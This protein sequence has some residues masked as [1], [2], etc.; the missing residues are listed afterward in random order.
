MNNSNM[1]AD[2]IDRRKSENFSLFRLICLG[3]S[4][5][6]TALSVPAQASITRTDIVL[7]SDGTPG[8][9]L[10]SGAG[11]DTG[12]TNQ[13]A[14]TNDTFEYL[15]TVRTNGGDNDLTIVATL[16]AGDVAPRTG[17]AV[18]KWSFVP[19][20][21]TGPGSSIS[22]N[23]QILTCNLGN[24]AST[25][26]Q[27]VY[28]N[29]TVLGTT[30]N[31][32]TM[33]SP[34]LLTSSSAGAG[35]VPTTTAPTLNITAAPYYD[36]V[37][38]MSYNGNPQAYGYRPASGPANEDGF[39]HRP[40]I[41]LVA[42]NPN[43]NGG[44]GVEQL[45]P[46][47][48]IDVNLD[49]SGYPSSVVLDNWH[50]GAGAA[51]TPAA[52]GSFVDGCGNTGA[53]APSSESGSS[54]NTYTFVTDTGAVNASTNTVYNGGD[55][56]VL[57]SSATNVSVRFSGT[58]TSF[59]RRP[60]IVVGTGSPVPASEWWMAQ[61][62]V[63]LWTP[64]ASYTPSVPVTHTVRLGGITATSIT[65]QP[66][67]GNVTTN[68]AA[69]Y[70]MQRLNSGSASQIW[71]ADG[72]RPVPFATQCDPGITGDCHTNYM[73][74]GQTVR[75]RTVYSNNGS[76]TQTNVYMCQVIDRTAMD[77][78]ANFNVLAVSQGSTVRYGSRAGGPYFP[79]TDSANDPYSGSS[80][81]S[82]A[83]S[84]ASCDDPTITW[85]STAA[86][87]QAAGGLVYVRA[88]MPTVDGGTT[89]YLYVDGLTLR[90]TS[91]ATIAVN[92]P[93]AAVR[94]AGSPITEGTLLRI[95]GKVGG[96][97]TSMDTAMLADQ[98]QVVQ[99]RNTT[100]IGKSVIAPTSNPTTP[101][102]SGSVV[103]YQ[104]RPRFSTYF[105]PATRTV[106]VTDILPPGATYVL[107]SATVGAVAQE[108]AISV[109]S[110][111]AG[112]TT[113]TWTL[114]SQ[115]PYMGADGAAANLQA[116]VFNAKL[117]STAA[118]GT[119]V[120][121]SAAASSGPDDYQADCT[122]ST[123]TKSFGACLKAASINLTIQ[124]PPGFR[125]EK[126]VLDPVAE[127]GE[128]F[129]YRLGYASLGQDIVGTDIPDLIDVLPFNGD[130]SANPALNFDART[131][132]TSMTNGA[133]LLQSVSPPSNDATM[134]ILYTKR[135]PSQIN[136][137]PQDASNALPGGSTEWCTS[138][139]FGTG[140][141]P[142][143]IGEAT[144]V[145]LQPS[146]A[147]MTS[148]TVYT[149]ILTFGT[150]PGTAKVGDVFANGV[151]ARSPD[152]GSSLL[153]IATQANGPV[154]LTTSSLSGR[155]FVDHNQNNVLDGA[156]SAI[157]NSCIVLTGTQSDST[158]VTH[159]MLTAADGSYGF[160]Y[161]AANTVFASGDC[162]SAASPS[163]GGVYH[164]T[165]QLRQL[166]QPANLG[167]G[168]D[169]AGT[170]GGTVGPDTSSAIVL[171]RNIA[172]T[173]YNFTEKA[174]ATL[175]G[176]VFTDGN[177]DHVINS[178][179]V[180]LPN[181]RIRL[182]GSFVDST[183]ATVNV[184]YYAC[185]ASDGTY[186][187]DGAHAVYSADPGA[188]C[189]TPG[190]PLTFTGL[191]P[192]TY[193][194]T[195]TTPA[196][197]AEGAAVVGTL[198]GTA[199]PPNTVSTIPL[200]SGAV[201]TGYLFTEIGS[202]PVAVDDSSTGLIGRPVT[203]GI[204]GNDT[205]L[206]GNIDPTR[207]VFTS[208]PPGA[209]L[210][211]DGKTLTVPG[212]GTW[213]INA[214]TGAATFTPIL[215]FVNN[216]TP[217]R[218]TVTDTTGLTSNAGLITITVS[219]APIA[220]TDDSVGGVNGASG[221]SNVLNVLTGDTLNL[222]PATT[223]TVTITVASGSSVPAG[224]VFDTATGN[225]SVNPGT[226]A[227][228]Y[229]FRYTICDTLN[230]GNCATAT[231]TVTVVASSIAADDDFA[232]STNGATG[233]NGVINAI[234][235]DMLNGSQA[236]LSDLNVSVVT[237]AT[238]IGGA[239]VPALNTTTGL[240]DVPAGTPAGNY[241]ILYRIC[242][243]L[244]PG[245]CVNATIHV[246]VSAASINGANDSQG[247]INGATG[248][249]NVLN[250]LGG[251]TLNGAPATTATVS[252][253]VAAGSTVPAGLTFDPATGNVSVNPGTPAGTYSFNYTICEI[254][255]PTNCFTASA[256]VTVVAAPISATDDTSAPVNG[257]TGG[258]GVIDALPN[259]S[260]NGAP[261]TLA[262]VTVAVVTPATPIG[263]ASVPV[264]DPATGL[265]NVPA[266]TPAGTYTIAYQICE[267]LNPANCA[268]A[269]ITVPVA[270]GP[271][272]AV[273]DSA[274][275]INGASGASNVLNV[276]TGDSRNGAPA[277]PA[278]VTIAVAA[279][280]TVPAGLTFDPA[281]GNVSVNPGTPAGTYS[282][283]YTICEVLNPA[284]CATATATVTVVPAPIV[285]VNDTVGDI[286]GGSGATNVLNAFTGDTING[287]PATPANAT[288]ALVPGV[289]LPA[290]FTFDAATGNVSV[291]PGTSD[292]TYSFDYLLCERLNPTN[293]TPA[294]MTVTVVPPRSTLSGIVYFDN[295]TNRTHEAGEGLLEGWIV[296]VIRGG[297]VVGTART[298]ALG[299]YSV[300]DLLSGPGY[301][302][303]FRHPANN[304]IYGKV[305][306]ATLPVNGTLAN[307]NLPV[308]PSGVVY[309]SI[310]RQP[311]A[312]SVVRLVD[313]TGAPLPAACFIDASQ[314]SQ[315]TGADGFYQ[316]DIVAGAA[317]QC[318]ASRTEYRLQVTAPTGYAHPV[319]TVLA[320]ESGAFNVSGRGNP[321]PVVAKATAPQVGDPATYYLAFLIA[322]G[323]GNVVNNHIPLDPFLTRTQL[324]VTKTSDKRTARTGDLVPYTITVRNTEGAQ[325]AAVSVVDILPPG[326]RYVPGS[327]RVN[328]VPTEPVAFDRELRWNA[329]TLAGNTTTTYQIVA[330]VG[331]GV[332]Q[333][334]RINTAL[335]RSGPTAGEISNRAQAI[336]SIVPSAIFDCAEIIGKVFDD[337]DGDGYQDKDEPGIP[338][339]RVAT[340][341][342]QLVTADEY[343]RYHITCAAVPDAQ[344]GSNFVLKLDP[345][346]IPEGYA[347]TSDNPQSIRLTRGKISELNFGVE[348][349]RVVSVAIDARAFV[350]GSAQLL[351]DFARRID[352]LK[353]VEAQRLVIQITYT[354][355]AGEAASLVEARLAGV[356]E[357]VATT[358][359]TGWDGPPP[360][361][362]AN[363]VS[364]TSTQ[365][366]E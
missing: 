252:I 246:P 207:T 247:G 9:D 131:P 217:V 126:T 295:N 52:S 343:G 96:T 5:L 65:G 75:G 341:N 262:T 297:V 47:Q 307:Q 6:F 7:A 346:T 57:S 201:A 173:G 72:S 46:A 223:S 49:I 329:Q 92:G 162:T 310:T 109:D 132:A 32:T 56:S 366:G 119:A 39:Y 241:A 137:D 292:G 243:K 116:I 151:G 4:M 248:A 268:P 337:L 249:S 163:F 175:A 179:D 71:S 24:F 200:T 271:I 293:C 226:P 186:A 38:Q 193:S 311:V 76:T 155:V 111:A 156:D 180:A 104:L 30:P 91:A 22:P 348:K 331:A 121:N 229:S 351:S 245:N 73:A 58:D 134:T 315:I 182:D 149:S 355:V 349:A 361:I 67:T 110:P 275:G 323:D 318:P 338:A 316:F 106:T 197:Y 250:V 152:V 148:N 128:T 286:N 305:E 238:P 154:R 120:P 196:S 281:T 130:G 107:G 242:E 296:E 321:A 62:A 176:Q 253:T 285:A 312:G 80:S 103:T 117:S 69:S 133:Y 159:S 251:D 170:S 239:P 174:L 124:T 97:G 40:M 266:N 264:L 290:G 356:R 184:T 267:R 172:A 135:A 216:P 314:A 265:V 204:V 258:T 190:A 274:T 278:T 45:N 313:T 115:M 357:Q 220:A 141:C 210:S 42:R 255:N 87:A 211:P 259:D 244:N 25:A 283:D 319:S 153:F 94:S 10:V 322:Q 272:T 144:A 84:T 77:I 365:G 26:T 118:D 222:A 160:V 191:T 36:V 82:S 333:G 208:P 29:A 282:F 345:R 147:T 360:V 304:V 122:Y 168:A 206:N 3:I 209:T 23:G 280:S 19:A 228:P 167:D 17:Q 269:T 327:A 198:S 178:G 1:V 279:G 79:S 54:I 254:L 230:P 183:G 113:L 88:D 301:T 332:T 125:I 236:V 237:P 294:T 219:A 43:G 288:V 85:H 14:R 108:P 127:P 306:N 157:G 202:P 326:F 221:A 353:P 63:V 102:P 33:A 27:S 256:T 95:V 234:P 16:P 101:L 192:G 328:N 59:A 18:A 64:I 299:F 233:A 11:F 129:R 81:N 161:G 289:V 189:S 330:V 300:T 303:Q 51:G 235:G 188:D 302:V 78:G 13:I 166:A 55:C 114:A 140:G 50:T 205:D 231:A 37:V 240:V 20:Q 227:G 344:I 363:L 354:S 335:A 165:Y 350:N 60:T 225:V 41:G 298:D 336:V 270:A 83:Y 358:F 158:P 308:D 86:D 218:Y 273:N 291:V 100:R 15:V 145:R 150:V 232:T 195:E 224:L 342:G 44:K 317:T 138:A 143:N 164:G 93:T 34:S 364:A 213:T 28:F 53:G 187:F 139:Q 324:L 70:V 214:T 48:P 89:N 261:A 8:W 99:M 185:T 21:C 61:K 339:A 68:D 347:P 98:L 257:G 277:I 171:G 325:R 263:G 123:I 181:V 12:A 203:I 31:T 334:D 105:P 74:A 112:Y 199:T 362:E 320:V 340:V 146:V 276:L 169:Y 309:D 284:N 177:G 287:L 194:L 35:P 352:G 142:A 90:S 66:I 215:G 359:R 212:E 2:R 260:L 136:V